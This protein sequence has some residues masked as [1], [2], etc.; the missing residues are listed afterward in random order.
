[1]SRPSQILS[2]TRPTNAGMVGV[3]SCSCGLAL[4]VDVVVIT[5]Y[6]DYFSRTSITFKDLFI[7]EQQLF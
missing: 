7:K 4:A 6:K 2:I 1:M 3:V 5:V